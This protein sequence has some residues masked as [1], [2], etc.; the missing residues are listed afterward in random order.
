MLQYE[1][2][3]IFA[4]HL[5]SGSCTVIASC[6]EM[7]GI[8]WSGLPLDRWDSYWVATTV[9]AQV[10][11]LI[12]ATCSKL[13]WHFILKCSHLARWCVRA[14]SQYV[15]VV[16]YVDIVVFLPIEVSTV[17]IHWC[18]RLV[19]C[20]KGSEVLVVIPIG[21][22]WVLDYI[23]ISAGCKSQGYAKH[24]SQRL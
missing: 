1:L 20:N 22:R 5:C 14:L 8:V 23:L 11:N 9:L 19:T 17:V 4:C 10:I 2:K 16:L 21:L 13:A 24:N 6:A 3:L 12:T 18:A 15:V 7:R